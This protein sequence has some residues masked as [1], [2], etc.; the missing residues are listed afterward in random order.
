[1][2]GCLVLDKPEG[3]SSAHALNMLKKFVRPNKIGHAG[4]LDPFAS[5]VLLVAIGQ[6]T[7][8]LEYVVSADKGYQ[9]TISWGTSTDTL[10]HTGQ[11]TATSNRAVSLSEIYEAVAKFPKNT[12]ISQTPPNYSAIHI[13][14]KRAYDMARS[15][16]DFEIPA[17]NVLLKDLSMA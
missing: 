2:Q 12:F 13:N 7:R 8:L 11:I 17:R 9:F 4:T 1:V 15:G 6:A 14:G 16:L 10:D 3:I 5:G